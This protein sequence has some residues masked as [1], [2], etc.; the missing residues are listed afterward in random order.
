MKP[1]SIIT[2]TAGT[3]L[4]GTTHLPAAEPVNAEREARLVP[5]VDGGQI[6]RTDLSSSD[7][8]PALRWGLRLSDAPLH[9]LKRIVT[10]WGLSMNGPIREAP[11]IEPIADAGDGAVRATWTWKA[12][13]WKLRID[14]AAEKA[15][16]EE[17]TSDEGTTK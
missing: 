2:I 4:L 12:R 7:D 17:R 13:T 5:L 11:Q 6:Q 15:L 14:P 16:V 8:D 3:L 9:S 1:R 10:L